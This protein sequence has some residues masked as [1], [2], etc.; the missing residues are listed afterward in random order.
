MKHSFLLAAAI[1]SGAL[2]GSAQTAAQGTLTK[3]STGWQYTQYYPNGQIHSTAAFMDSIH[4]FHDGPSIWFDSTGKPSHYSSYQNNV[5][6][7][8][9]TA[10]FPDGR[11]KST[12]EW[13]QGKRDGPWTGFYPSG[14]LSGTAIYKQGE[15]R[16]VVGYEEDGTVNKAIKSFAAP[17]TYPGGMDYWM[18]YL[19]RA[20]DY[21]LSARE[22]HHEGYAVIMFK[23]KKDGMTSNYKVVRSAG[24]PLLDEAAI[25]VIKK[26]GKWYPGIDDGH[27]IE[28]FISQ[29]I[30]FRLNQ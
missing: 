20:L 9:D 29:P 12:G 23:V 19:H 25:D 28:M 18:S 14:K 16:E 22:H 11:I 27:Y 1:L 17:A 26:S 4:H 13:K 8:P 10:Y 7:G 3:T 6:S 5:L 21:P 15:A 24:D 30:N 2:R